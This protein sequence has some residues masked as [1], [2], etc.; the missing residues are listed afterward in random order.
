MTK[1]NYIRAVEQINSALWVR[2][3]AERKLL[4]ET[5][6]D[7]FQEDNPRF[8]RNRFLKAVFNEEK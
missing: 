8:D 4:A 3:D 5:F 2:N 7:F 6:A 1:K